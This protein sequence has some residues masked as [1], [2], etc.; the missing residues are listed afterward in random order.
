MS[1]DAISKVTDAM[2]QRLEAAVGVGNVYVGP[3]VAADVGSRRLALFLFHI[4]P[5]QAMRNETHYVP[6]PTDPQ[7]PLV[8]VNAIPLDLRYLV[9]AFRTAGA[10]GDGL[11]DP[12]EMDNLGAAIQQ[13][14]AYPNI[15]NPAIPNEFARITPEPYTMEDISRVWG[16][17]PQTSYQTSMV[18]LVSPV[19]VALDPSQVPARVTE[20]RY[21]HGP[22]ADPVGTAGGQRRTEP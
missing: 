22:F 2:H 18:Y 21:G 20:R 7:T 12:D 17:M 8:E 4:L 11:A 1:K 3:P 6:V 5:N 14:H 10:G 9:S 15:D 16:L 13:F 19:F